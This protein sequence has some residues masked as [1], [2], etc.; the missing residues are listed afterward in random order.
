[1]NE[2]RPR[3]S[4]R[5]ATLQSA[6][7]RVPFM[8]LLLL[9]GCTSRPPVEN[10][11]PPSVPG[12]PPQVPPPPP[13]QPREVN[14]AAKSEPIALEGSGQ[15]V[16]AKG[17]EGKFIAGMDGGLY[18]PYRAILIER[19]QRNLKERGLYVGPINGTLDSPTMKAI[20]TFQ[21]ATHILQMC[22]VPTPRTRKLLEQGSH[23][24]V[25]S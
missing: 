16:W 14:D 13:I 4:L 6:V 7:L 12:Q 18:E 5:R 15:V 3:S 8:M 11:K 1:M 9:Y 21:E 24:D 10:T 2:A 20:Y 25:T 23:T 17:F 22:G 19:I